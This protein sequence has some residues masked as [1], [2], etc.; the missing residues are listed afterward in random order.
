M[1]T[2]DADTIEKT[3]L[4]AFPELD[5]DRMIVNDVPF[6]VPTLDGLK[7]VVGRNSVKLLRMSGRFQCE[8]MC[9]TLL[10]RIRNDPLLADY[11]HNLCIGMAGG[12]L[13]SGLDRGVHMR[14]LA[15][16]EDA[17]R[18]QIE[19]QDDRIWPVD[20][21]LFSPFNLWM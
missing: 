13:R 10:S 6:L 7:A 15:M 2:I 19:A 3:Y 12:L 8:E 16:T 1:K 21:R 20:P 11:D 14:L 4:A 17:G 5:R 9:L 18:V